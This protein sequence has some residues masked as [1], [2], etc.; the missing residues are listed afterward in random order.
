ARDRAESARVAIDRWES[1]NGEALKGAEELRD[2]LVELDDRFRRRA[3]F[4]VGLNRRRR[5]ERDLLDE[6]PRDA[7]WW[8]TLRSDCDD[9][10]RLLAGT[11]SPASDQHLESC[12]LCR[13]DL[14]RSRLVER[15]PE[16]HLTSEDAWKLD[17]GML[18]P[19]EARALR[20]HAEGCTSC[21]AL[22]HAMDEGEKAIA[23]LEREDRSPPARGGAARGRDG[24]E[25][26][27]R[28]RRQVALERREFR[29]VVL[30]DRGRV[31]LLVEPR[32]ARGFAAAKVTIP[33]QRKV[34]TPK[35]TGDG[36]EFDL[37]PEQELQGRTA[38]VT[39]KITERG[40]PIQHEVSL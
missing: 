18:A 29:L 23:E 30:R 4:L 34:L 27:A 26:R 24:G 37:G 10:M 14:R 39:L 33:P 17:L 8:F 40:E 36:L 5:V 20:R 31:R 22:I 13:E 32:E 6:A 21:T 9:L 15:P 16:P 28:A 19:E 7:A 38:R 11:A 1:L 3:R 12:E 25:K 35:S 2:R